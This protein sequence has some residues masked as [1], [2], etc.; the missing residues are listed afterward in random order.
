MV[1]YD[2]NNYIG[3]DLGGLSRDVT[4]QIIHSFK[5]LTKDEQIQGWGRNRDINL[6]EENISYKT[7]FYQY[8]DQDQQTNHQPLEDNLAK[9]LECGIYQRKYH[10]IISKLLSNNDQKDT[11]LK[12]VKYQQYLTDVIEKSALLRS[13]LLQNSQDDQN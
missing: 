11:F 9:D 13:K 12:N 5:P 7:K 10:N 8:I 2:S 4:H 6:R 1:F 3:G